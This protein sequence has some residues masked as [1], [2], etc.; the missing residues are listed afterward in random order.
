MKLKILREIIAVRQPTHNNMHPEE[1]MARKRKQTVISYLGG[2]E[3][4]TPG[5]THT[6]LIT[7]TSTLSTST[8]SLTLALST[9]MYPVNLLQFFFA[10]VMRL[11][12]SQHTATVG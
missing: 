11:K 1:N 9:V 2:G 8:C 3:V 6:G 4:F 12:E 7:T 5:V 10:E